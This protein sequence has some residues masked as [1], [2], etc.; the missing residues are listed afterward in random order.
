MGYT[1]RDISNI[2]ILAVY[3]YSYDSNTLDDMLAN[4]GQAIFRHNNRHWK[5]QSLDSMYASVN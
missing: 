4:S 3:L 1:L 2:S 5:L